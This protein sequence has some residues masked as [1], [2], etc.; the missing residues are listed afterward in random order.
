[1]K[2]V[3]RQILFSTLLIAMLFSLLAGCN[4]GNTADK[5]AESTTK[6]EGAGSTTTAATT[7]A[8]PQELSFWG[9]Q[10]ELEDAWLNNL[11]PDFE[12]KNPGVKVSMVMTP[13]AQYWQKV[14]TSLLSNQLPDLLTMSVGLVDQYAANDAIIN[15]KSYIDKDLDR[16]QF[17]ESGLRTVK[18]PSMNTGDEYAFPWNIVCNTLYYNKDMFDEAKV[19]YPN[20]DW[21]WDDLLDAA[22]KLTNNTGNRS[23]S[24]F[25]FAVRNNYTILDSV[26][27]SY[28]G[29]IISDDFK[30]CVID[31]PQAIQAMSMLVDMIHVHKVSPPI[32]DTSQEG[33]AFAS[34]QVAMEVGGT[35]SWASYESSKFKWDIAPLPKGPAG[36]AIRSWSDSI[37]IT[38]DSKNPDLA[39]AFI[40]HMVGVDGQTIENL[41]STRIPI[42][43]SASQSDEWLQPSQPPESKKGILD[44]LS[45]SDPFV[46]R[47]G[48]LEWNAAVG[49]GTLPA[50]LKKTSVEE[51]AKAT[52]ATVQEILD[53][54]K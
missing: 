6:A 51:A 36:R 42:L 18:W 49:N 30:T 17:Y 2:K 3:A 44:F 9:W 4:S 48:W 21:T 34:G 25:G 29:A 52:R 23:T 37:A 43:I 15:L 13:W 27:Y 20:A 19:S 12:A 31:S 41:T 32:S 50:F 40:K 14:Q 45:E 11:I 28:G 47:N 8:E 22:K 53:K 10:G 1:M 16:K 33:E 7:Q 24:R 54:K 38:K 26:I 5:S 35:Y 46:F 39:W